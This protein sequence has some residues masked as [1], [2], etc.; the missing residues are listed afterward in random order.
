MRKALKIVIWSVV[1]FIFPLAA[2]AEDGSGSGLIGIGAGLA[3]FSL[4][5][6]MFVSSGI[7]FLGLSLAVCFF[8]EPKRIREPKPGYGPASFCW[9][10]Q[11]GR[12]ATCLN[13]QSGQ[14]QLTLARA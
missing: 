2:S 8:K 12:P 13:G 11:A 4:R 7:A 3:E 5:T 6:P 9:H 10:R 1:L 14:L